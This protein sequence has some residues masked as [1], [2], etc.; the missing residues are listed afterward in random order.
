[1]PYYTLI[2]RVK[3]SCG[4]RCNEFTIIRTETLSN[5]LGNVLRRNGLL[6]VAMNMAHTAAQVGEQGAFSRYTCAQVLKVAELDKWI[7]QT[8]NYS[9]YDKRCK[10]TSASVDERGAQ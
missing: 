4:V 9:D 8:F 1:M 6:P 2:Q 5:D 10:N 7:Y 3:R